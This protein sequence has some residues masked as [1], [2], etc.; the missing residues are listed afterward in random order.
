MKRRLYI[1]FICL[2]L[3]KLSIQENNKITTYCI[4]N[5]GWKVYIVSSFYKTLAKKTSDQLLRKLPKAAKNGAKR[6]K[7]VII[8]VS[9][10]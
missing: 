3:S 6:P 7:M 8:G 10:D 1:N 2:I 5:R 4:G 9:R